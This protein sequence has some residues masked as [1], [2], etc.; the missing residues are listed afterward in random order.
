MV[1]VQT[2]PSNH[3]IFKKGNAIYHLISKVKLELKQN[4]N[5]YSKTT[6]KEA[7]SYFYHLKMCSI[8]T[9]PKE[10]LYHSWLKCQPQYVFL[11]FFQVP[12]PFISPWKEKDILIHCWQN[13]L[14]LSFWR[15]TG[16]KH[17]SFKKVSTFWSKKLI[18]RKLSKRSN[19]DVCQVVLWTSIPHSTIGDWGKKPRIGEQDFLLRTVSDRGRI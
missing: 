19:K 1:Y 16:N 7:I 17:Q 5:I 10:N 15:S 4:V 6:C 12:F 11:R 9:H 13:K 14:L 2:S 3:Q 18:L 8:W